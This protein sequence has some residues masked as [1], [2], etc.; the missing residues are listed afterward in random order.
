[1]DDTFVLLTKEPTPPPIE[2]NKENSEE[3]VTK[4]KTKK[5]RKTRKKKD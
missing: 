1:M 4:E 3:F 2:Y 5:K